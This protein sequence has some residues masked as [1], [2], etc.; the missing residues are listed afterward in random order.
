MPAQP[1]DLRHAIYSNASG[2]ALKYAKVNHMHPQPPGQP[3]QHD[4]EN[5]S[6][7]SNSRTSGMHL[8]KGAVLE[9]GEKQH[10]VLPDIVSIEP[11]V[12]LFIVGREVHGQLEDL[13]RVKQRAHHKLD[14]L[15][16]TNRLP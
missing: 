16:C 10:H 6:M 12:T 13:C 7:A 2:A 9:E 8:M 5:S 15:R 11:G 1:L 4:L 14:V 3:K